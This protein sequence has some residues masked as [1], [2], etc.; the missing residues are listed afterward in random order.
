MV[1][2]SSPRSA[3]QA[4]IG[5]KNRRSTVHGLIKGAATVALL[6]GGARWVARS[7]NC[8]ALAFVLADHSHGCGS[9]S[10]RSVAERSFASVQACGG[11]TSPR[12]CRMAV[13]RV[14]F[15]DV[16]P[17]DCSALSQSR[18]LF[19]LDESVFVVRFRIL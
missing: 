9:G 2:G 16:D 13:S 7:R 6:F 8:V 17:V 11:K 14:F 19:E 5:M 1:V 18:S 10:E 4:R 3:Y 12:Y 15:L